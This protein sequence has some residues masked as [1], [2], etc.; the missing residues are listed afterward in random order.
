MGQ[1]WSKKDADTRCENLVKLVQHTNRVSTWVAASIVS[2]PTIRERKK[3]VISFIQL[4]QVRHDDTKGPLCSREC[5]AS[6]A[7]KQL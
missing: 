3:L 2:Y 1:A 6:A 5:T 4:L 7:A